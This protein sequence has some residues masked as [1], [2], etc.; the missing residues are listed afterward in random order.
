MQ[1]ILYICSRNQWRSPTA[2]GGRMRKK[3]TCIIYFLLSSFVYLNANNDVQTLVKDNNNFTFELYQELKTSKENIFFSPYS[4]YTAFAMTY[5]GAKHKTEKEIAKTLGYSLKEALP[6]S[7]AKLQLQLDSINTKEIVLSTVNSLWAQKDYTFLDSFMDLNK[8]YYGS[9]IYFVDYKNNPEKA[10]QGINTWV[11]KKTKNKIKE[12]LEPSKV[13]NL[14]KLILCNAI[15]FKGNWNSKFDSKN[16]HEK[17]FYISKRKTKKCKMMQQKQ[18]FRYEDFGNFSAIELPYKGNHLSMIVFLPKEIDGLSQ[19][20]KSL[21]G[22]NV[23][24]WIE[25]LYG[26]NKTKISLSF[27]RFKTTYA[28]SLKKSLINMGMP[29]PFS[30]S[31]DFSGMTGTKYLYI[32][33]AIHK[34]FIEINEK[35]SEAAAA[36]AVIISTKRLYIKKDLEIKADHPFIF[37]IKENHTGTILFMGRVLDPSK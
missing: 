8:K 12:L 37:F 3:I 11:E 4:I 18:K 20:E 33:D 13:D 9:S 16:T 34:A 36:T 29:T 21:N 31:A 6:P 24:Q 5:A 2:E 10:R 28:T 1:N 19:L 17:D 22:D 25:S 14:T 32:D 7:L 23:E 26:T 35:G 15:Y 30:G 27:P